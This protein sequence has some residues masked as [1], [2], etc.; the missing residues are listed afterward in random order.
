MIRRSTWIILAILLAL[1][2]VSF[3]VKDQK[4]RRTA[5]ATPTAGAAALFASAEGTP[6][7]ILIEGSNGVTVHISRDQ[8]GKWVLRAP[9]QADA[10]Q[11]SAEAAATQLGALRV[12]SKVDLGPDVL[13]LDKPAATLTISYGSGKT[14]KLLVGS[15]TPIQSGY[16]VQ[17]DGGPSQ[18]VEKGG[19]DA[20]LALLAKPPYLATLTPVASLTPSAPAP[21]ETSTPAPS[22]SSLPLT[23]TSAATP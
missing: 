5:E 3:Y 19:L 9:V 17:L 11:A 10:D 18:V 6:T 23:P 12:V 22:P 21:T 15:I 13:G 4:V 16:Y 20:L 1:V 14:H 8:T 2:G 7:D